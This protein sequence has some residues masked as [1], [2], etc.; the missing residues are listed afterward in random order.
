MQEKCHKNI[1][2]EEIQNLV[3]AMNDGLLLM[4]FKVGKFH[5]FP[6]RAQ[7]GI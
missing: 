6:A 2:C 4:T 3:A 5:K 1:T 7:F